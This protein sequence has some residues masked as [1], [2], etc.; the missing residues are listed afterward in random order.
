MAQE[1]FGSTIPILTFDGDEAAAVELANDTQYGLSA[2]VLTNDQSRAIEMTQRINAGM[3]HVN[4]ISGHDG[5]FIP[6][7]GIKD[8]GLG[9]REG[10]GRWSIDATS[11]LK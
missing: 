10:G 7:G 4:D 11:E 3:V 9:G 5:P 1:T 6:F 2:A 8:S